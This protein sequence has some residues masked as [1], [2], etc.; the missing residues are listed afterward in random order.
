MISKKKKLQYRIKK[1]KFIDANY[2]FI[3]GMSRCGKGG[4]S[5][6]V[7]SFKRVDHF[8]VESYIR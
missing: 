6:V 3:D 1:I 2:L 5:P 8:R 7:S 4:I